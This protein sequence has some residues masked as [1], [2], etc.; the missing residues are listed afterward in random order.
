MVF[1]HRVG[2]VGRLRTGQAGMAHTRPT[3]H[4]AANRFIIDSDGPTWGYQSYLSIR[5]KKGHYHEYPEVRAGRP[6][7]PRVQR[8]GQETADRRRVERE[9]ASFVSESEKAE[10]SAILERHAEDQGV[11][12]HNLIS[13]RVLAGTEYR[14]A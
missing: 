2:G 5:I 4:S 14:A 8:V 10:L 12:I 9:L 3:W 11:E 13:E 1:G 7:S 6:R